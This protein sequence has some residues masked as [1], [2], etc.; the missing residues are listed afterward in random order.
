MKLKRIL[1]GIAALL[2]VGM[3]YTFAFCMVQDV[4]EEE[5][6]AE[7]QY[8]EK[9]A[10]TAE[11]EA[12]DTITEME[13]P[14]T[15]EE[16]EEENFLP[17][18]TAEVP[19]RIIVPDAVPD[20]DVILSA[21]P[22]ET[23]DDPEEITDD[24]YRENSELEDYSDEEME[25]LFLEEDNVYEYSEDKAD[26]TNGASK[27]SEDTDE[28]TEAAEETESKA[29]A[30]ASADS[31]ETAPDSG[32]VT[33]EDINNND[34][35]LLEIGSDD[36][37]D[38]PENED[39]FDEDAGVTPEESAVPP[40]PAYYSWDDLMGS[41]E[42]GTDTSYSVG[43]GEVF[44]AKVG[45]SV[46]EFDAFELVCMITA[47]EVSASFNKE[48]IKA[49][50]VAAYS[51]V[52]YH[53]VNGLTP[54]VL[55]KKNIP[56]E[57]REAVSEVWGQCCYYNGKVAQTVYTASTSGYSASAV[58][59][60]GGDNFP[61]LIGK[62]C[63]FDADY[64]PNYGVQ[65][66]YTES[67]MRHKLENYLGI[68]LSDDPSQWLNITEYEDGN[69][70]KTIL[71][72]GQAAINGRQMRE[73]VLKFGIKSAAFTVSYADGIF[74][75]TTYGYGHGVGLSQNGANILG[76]QGYSYVDILK[77]YFTG[78]TVE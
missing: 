62:E 13:E 34:D 12:E 20:E 47:N 5:I 24:N 23:E 32:N 41:S 33:A 27:S 69:Y 39:Q 51:Y 76:K 9:E 57:I 75:I 77:F 66:T 28:K 1:N 73:K 30:E 21:V 26:K 29:E 68:Q 7:Y 15:A 3:F 17:L 61:Y 71:V 67:D 64:D 52:K 36:E 37:F 10:E 2:S 74:T 72:D 45:G 40:T 31:S 59:V 25:E 49:Q 54:S 65:V 78:I 11:E 63:P 42:S 4:Q 43:S 14:D 53:Q 56:D 18:L 8:T 38:A 48:A 19:S 50:A 55:V 44:T 60:W 35:E 70:V 6:A 16:A 22:R 58:N 46:Q